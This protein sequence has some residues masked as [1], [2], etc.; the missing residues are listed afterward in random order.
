MTRIPEKIESKFRYILVASARAEQI[1]RGAPPKVDPGHDKPSRIAMREV[2]SDLVAWEL[3][4][5]AEEE[6]V[7]AA[8]A[9]EAAVEEA[10]DEVN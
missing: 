10:G 2:S 7:E 4:S 5:P 6:V 1:M 3:G 9:S 8:D